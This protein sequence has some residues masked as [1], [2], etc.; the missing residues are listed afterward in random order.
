MG[1]GGI[2]SNFKGCKQNLYA[3]D[4]K[5]QVDLQETFRKFSTF[6]NLWIY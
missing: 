4:W 3:N 6:D 5:L 2:L 1:K